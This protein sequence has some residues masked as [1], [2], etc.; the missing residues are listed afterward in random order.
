MGAIVLAV[1]PGKVTGYWHYD[2]ADAA[3]SGQGGELPQWEFVDAAQL[4]LFGAWLNSEVTVVCESFTITQRSVVQRGDRV[5]SLEQIGILQ[6]MVRMRRAYEP[7]KPPC[8]YAPEQSPSD[9]KSFATDKKLRRI[10]WYSRGNEHGRDAA[11]HAL[12]YAVRNGHVMPHVL[13]DSV[14]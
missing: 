10:G 5:W 13:L 12:L 2:P 8:H 1:D 3:Y 7:Q 14:D 4:M 11:R 6:Y 9:A